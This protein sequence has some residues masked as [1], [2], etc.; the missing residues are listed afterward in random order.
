LRTPR[1]S[2]PVDFT[3][4]SGTA[5]AGSSLRVETNT[6]LV[7]RSPAG[8]AGTDDIVVHFADGTA[9]A[10]TPADQ[11]TYVP[12]PTVTGV[13]P[14][15]GS[16]TGG[17]N[18]TISGTNLTGATQVFFGSVAA[19]SFTVKNAG[20]I[21][22]TSPPTSGT[23]NVGVV[24]PS[25][26]SATSSADEYTYSGGQSAAQQV[27][28]TVAFACTD[29]LL[30]TGISVP[31]T[32][33]GQVPYAVAPSGSASLANAQIGISL[34]QSY[35]DLLGEI[36]A[37]SFLI[38]TFTVSN[39]AA[40]VTSNGTPASASFPGGPYSIAQTLA[41][42]FG[43]FYAVLPSSAV[44]LGSFTAPSSGSL[45]ITPGSFGFQ[46]NIIGNPAAP[47]LT[48]TDTTTC[49]LPRGGAAALATIP[50]ETAPTVTGVSPG[51]GSP[52]GGTAVTIT[53]TNLLGASAVTFGPNA[54]SSFTVNSATSISAVSPPG[55]GTVDVRV[56]T[57]S[58]TS[59]TSSADHFAY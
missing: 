6:A 39:V 44:S 24:T 29:G 59:A 41:D 3:T 40:G 38:P 23:V 15:G 37:I 20:S 54:A 55:S 50:V 35:F 13:S 58:G 49:S 14:A 53:G 28:T 32:F 9:T 36:D 43:S 48:E 21:T 27:S 31:I 18:V 22:A 11:F 34:N 52:S 17:A 47:T 42:G 12:S 25:G 1:A 51:S 30:G 10:V 33:T 56:T 26:Q 8:A 45:T 57:Q 16:T 4:S 7:V 5:T 2:R 46:L 19:S